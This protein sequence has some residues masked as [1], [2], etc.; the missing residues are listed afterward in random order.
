MAGLAESSPTF[1]PSS[2]LS[3]RTRM[4]PPEAVRSSGSAR[5]T[6]THLLEA[7]LPIDVLYFSFGQIAMSFHSRALQSVPCV[8][9]GAIGCGACLGGAKLPCLLTLLF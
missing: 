2:H 4:S 6:A 9:T 8:W 3:Q 5:G 7:V 1:A